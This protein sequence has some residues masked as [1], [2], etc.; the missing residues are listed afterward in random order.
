[1]TRVL[2]DREIEIPPHALPGK[3]TVPDL[4]SGLI[5]FAHG[6]GSSRLSPR[7]TRVARSLN[8]AG[9][10]TLLF[11]LLS[12]REAEDRSNVFN[13]ALLA[14]RLQQAI[15]WCVGNAETAKMPIGLFG[16]STGAAAA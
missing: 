13:I 15:N 8:G 4:A 11:D 12:P 10:A 14:E 9:L 3:L 7:N 6:S 5:I 2:H 16:A 1:M